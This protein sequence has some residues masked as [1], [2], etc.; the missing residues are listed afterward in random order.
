MINPYF[1][2]FSP[3][4]PPPP[5]KNYGKAW[6]EGESEQ[7]SPPRS[8][9]AEGRGG[10]APTWTHLDQVKGGHRSRWSGH[11]QSGGVW[12]TWGEVPGSQVC[13][14]C[15]GGS[16]GFPG[17]LPVPWSTWRSPQDAHQG[18]VRVS[19]CP[20]CASGVP[21]VSSVA[22]EGN[23]E[24]SMVSVVL[25]GRPH[26]PQGLQVGFS[27][28][29]TQDSLGVHGGGCPGPKV[30]FLHG[31]HGAHGGT[32]RSPGLHV[33]FSMVP[34]VPM[35]GSLRSPGCVW[36]SWGSPRSPA[37]FLHVLHGAHGGP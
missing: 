36:C 1:C 12:G 15:P 28:L 22:M 23:S 5:P 24:V 13:P 20:G 32:L 25:T 37:E 2:S 7:T 35:E 8:P 16:P 11:C 10:T 31:L 3:K 29:E 19:R 26:G 9:G 18:Q 33:G 21:T 4:F 17:P 14:Q 6:K 27:I 34:M 30:G